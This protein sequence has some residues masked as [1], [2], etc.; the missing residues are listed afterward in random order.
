MSNFTPLVT[1]QYE[2][3]G[4]QVTVVFSRLKRKHMIAIMPALAEFESIR[5][6]AGDN[7]PK[8][9]QSAAMTTILELLVDKLPE[10]VKD[11]SGL[12]DKDG[13]AIEFNLVVDE[14]YFMK[15]VTEMAIDLVTESTFNQGKA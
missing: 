15:L 4:D 11:F 5:E 12:R 10:Y 14:T 3:E 9:A 7:S 6:E 2:F 8:L 13:N 1:K